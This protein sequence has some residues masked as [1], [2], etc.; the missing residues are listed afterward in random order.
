MMISCPEVVVEGVSAV[1]GERT[2]ENAATVRPEVI[3]ATGFPVR[4]T[5]AEGTTLFDLALRAARQLPGAADAFAI[6]GVIAATF[7][8]ENRFPSLAVRL[9]SSLGLAPETAA[10]DVQMACSAYP[11]ALYLAGRLAAD[12]GKKV[13][14]VDGDVQSRLS[15]NAATGTAE[16]FSDAATATLVS[17]GHGDP[18][19]FAFLSRASQALACPADGPIQMDGFKVFAF[20]ATEV[21]KFLKPFC[22]KPFAAFV[23]HQANMYMVRQLAKALNV[24]ERLVT[25]GADVANPGSCSVPLALARRGRRGE[26]VLV[27]GFGAGLSASAGVI[28][29]SDNFSGI[30]GDELK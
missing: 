11:Y 30:V 27:A 23:P 1:V 10:F 14:V 20:V 16:L 18:S 2:V 3:A 13:L 26:R 7:S 9:A 24:E 8:H 29:L 22:E 12:T 4:R 21:A 25:C 28:R 19:D 6:G 5:V 15:Q 17:S